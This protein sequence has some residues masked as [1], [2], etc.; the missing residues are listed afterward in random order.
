MLDVLSCAR[1]YASYVE[2]RGGF[3]FTIRVSKFLNITIFGGLRIPVQENEG[4]LFFSHF[5]WLLHVC[6]FSNT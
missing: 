1:F 6:L 2:F 3:L 5:G 4:M